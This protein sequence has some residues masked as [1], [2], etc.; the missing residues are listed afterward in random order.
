MQTEP[1]QI[2]PELVPQATQIVKST[3]SSAMRQTFN[4][5]TIILILGFI[6]SIFIP[7]NRKLNP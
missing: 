1:P 7:K 4:A 2:P 5:L 6:T 3:V